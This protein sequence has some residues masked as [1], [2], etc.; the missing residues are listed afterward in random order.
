MNKEEITIAELI[1]RIESG[2]K[3]NI[4]LRTCELAQLFGVYESAV[5]ANI[6][7]IIKNNIIKPDY[8]ST[9]VQA[10]KILLPELYDLD[11]I[12]ALA[13]RIDSPNADS[14]RNW[15]LKKVSKASDRLSNRL[16]LIPLN[17]MILN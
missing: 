3:E 16:F 8:N 12:I 13:F 17:S 14:L 9:L 6:K 7:S 11:I 5:R 10:G 4:R 1:K 2:E 15:I